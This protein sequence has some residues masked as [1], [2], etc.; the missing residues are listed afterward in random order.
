MSVQDMAIA[1][2]T[3]WITASVIW[4]SLAAVAVILKRKGRKPYCRKSKDPDEEISYA[5]PRCGGTVGVYDM[6]DKY[7]SDCGQKIDWRKRE[8]DNG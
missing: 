1:Y 2:S 6:E 7:C 8:K 3:G 4:L 5:C